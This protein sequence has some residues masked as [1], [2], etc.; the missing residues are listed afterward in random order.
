M[1]AIYLRHSLSLPLQ[2]TSFCR[3]QK[4]PRVP[5]SS[6]K[7]V[8]TLL[9]I[10]RGTGLSDTPTLLALFWLFLAGVQLFAYDF[11]AIPGIWPTFVA[12]IMVVSA[13]LGTTRAFI[14]SATGI[15]IQPPPKTPVGLQAQLAIGLASGL[16]VGAAVYWIVSFLNFGS[17]PYDDFFFVLQVLSWHLLC[18]FE[19]LG[20]T[21]GL[22][23]AMAQSAFC[24]RFELGRMLSRWPSLFTFLS[25]CCSTSFS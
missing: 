8:W 9:Q 16:V 19:I 22:T 3:R 10:A 13:L 21:I 4:Q 14:I 17:M 15:R 23:I 12:Q 2:R 6:D 5:A 20:A 1:Y 11:H 7:D 25:S 18:C 24:P